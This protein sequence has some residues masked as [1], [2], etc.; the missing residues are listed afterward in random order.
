MKLRS[1]ADI[2]KTKRTEPEVEDVRQPGTDEVTLT[3]VEADGRTRTWSGILRVP[4]P[5]ELAMAGA[6]WAETF[7]VNF[8]AIPLDLRAHLWPVYKLAP[9][10][11][12]QPGGSE[13]VG[14]L[15]RDHELLLLVEREVD[16]LRAEMFPRHHP[17]RVDEKQPR[18]AIT[19]RRRA[20]DPEAPADE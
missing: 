20:A 5:S 11:V 8:A 12:T 6:R 15:E 10:L 16:A 13:L 17:D 18:V 2:F 3:W 7:G 14:V 9:Q 19:A 1:A 4:L